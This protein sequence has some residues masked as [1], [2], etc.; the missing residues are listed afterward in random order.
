M[1]MHADNVNEMICPE[2]LQSLWRNNQC[3]CAHLPLEAGGALQAATKGF[4]TVLCFESSPVN[5]EATRAAAREQ[6][7]SPLGSALPCRPPCMSCDALIIPALLSR[8][9]CF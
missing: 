6:D 3:Q 4:R 5:Y 8:E 9:N 1:K 2:P 7:V